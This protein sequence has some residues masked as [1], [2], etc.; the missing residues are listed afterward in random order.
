MPESIE[1]EGGLFPE[2]LGDSATWDATRLGGG[3][4][5]RVLHLKKD[6]Q[7]YTLKQYSRTGERDRYTSEKVFY[8]WAAEAGSR[9]IPRPIAW[10][11][12]TQ[13]GLFS[14]VAGKA[15]PSRAREND[16]LQAAEFIVALN[17][18]RETANRLPIPEAADT[19]DWP[20]Q[21]ARI[22]A[23]V[24][25]LQN[26]SS[27]TPL[28]RELENFLAGEFLPA[29]EKVSNEFQTILSHEPELAK[30]LPKEMCILSPSD[31]GFHNAL[32][33]GDG[34]LTFFDFEYAGWDDPAKTA[35]DFLRQ[36]RHTVPEQYWQGFLQAVSQLTPE[37]E[38]FLLRT[39]YLLPLHNFKWCC[40]FLNDF[41][42]EHSP[43]RYAA[44]GKDPQETQ[45]L[46]VQIE[47]ARYHLNSFQPTLDQAWP[48]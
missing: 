27:R 23:R 46:H 16:V 9:Q 41:L 14:Y 47:K 1:L 36:P 15:T 33:G 28:R 26:L 44:F 42:P 30:P 19:G 40:I 17:Q 25:R 31:F 2:I 11:D 35:S 10:E 6:G 12:G 34:R 13:S 37:P 3:A 5:N 21:H 29:W 18:K 20:T 48:T 8:G 4:N 22:Q 45:T 43:R 7:E 24:E 39:R 32:S 38:Q